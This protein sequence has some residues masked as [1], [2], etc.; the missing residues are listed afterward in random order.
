MLN[1]S[2]DRSE[3]REEKTRIF[4][5]THIWI[6][7]I[8][9]YR[10]TQ[11][12]YRWVGHLY[13]LCHPVKPQIE[14]DCREFFFGIFFNP[15]CWAIPFKCDLINETGFS[16]RSN[17]NVQLCAQ[18]VCV[19]VCMCVGLLIVSFENISCPNNAVRFCYITLRSTTH[20]RKSTLTE[21]VYLA[22]AKAMKLY[23]CTRDTLS[24]MR[25]CHVWVC[26]TH[27]SHMFECVW[28]CGAD[29]VTTC[30]SVYWHNKSNS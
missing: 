11:R 9:S 3:R 30:A 2:S 20:K 19:Y 23:T 26:D 29:T 10:V 5:N 28:M 24:C 4:T 12:R 18:C 22:I 8:I 13:L 14:L 7:A 17:E 27:Y 21:C 6:A 25:A 16:S 15:E 1:Q